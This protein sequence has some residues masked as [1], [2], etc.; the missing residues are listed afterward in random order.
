[1]T[2]RLSLNVGFVLGMAGIAAASTWSAAQQARDTAA[3]AAEAASTAVVAGTV[4]SDEAQ[5]RPVR[6]AKLT[7]AG[8]GLRGS[9]DTVTDD[10]GRFAFSGLAAGDYTLMAA[11]AGWITTYFG[12][13]HPGVRP[14][15]SAPLTMAA[16]ERNTTLVL[17]LLHGSAVSGTILDHAGRPADVIVRLLQF[18]IT[19]GQRTLVGASGAHTTDST[20]DRG[21]YRLYGIAP[22]EYVV[23]TVIQSFGE[24]DLHQVTAAVLQSA[25]RATSAGAVAPSGSA[26]SDQG[27]TVAYANVYYPGT[28][29]MAEAAIVKIGPDEDKSGVDFSLQLVPTAQISGAIVSPD[30]QPARVQVQL[31]PRRQA[32][33]ADSPVLG[34]FAFLA[35][36]VALTRVQADGTFKISAVPP[37]QYTV[38]AR[39]A[40]RSVAPAATADA[41]GPLGRAGGAAALTL[42]ASQDVTVS[43]RDISGV[44][45]NLQP[46][47]TVSGHVTSDI[48]GPAPFDFT[49]VAVVLNS[50][51][52]GSAVAPAAVDADGSFRLS[53]VVPGRYRLN[54]SA[55][56]NGRRAG[57]G[58]N[59]PSDW[60]VASAFVG[61]HDAIDLPFQVPPGE[62]ITDAAIKLTSALS[63]I[64]GRL[65]DAAGQPAHDY[66]I[67]VFSADRGYWTTTGRR[68]PPPTAT[69]RDGTFRISN[70]PA[71]E[72]LVLV[73]T[74]I[75][76]DTLHDPAQLETLSAQAVRVRLADGEKK[77]QDFKIGG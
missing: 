2:R 29:D 44:T 77:V 46:G 22:G 54:V 42:W 53:G 6:R 57:G 49:R 37:G 55:S 51:D 21:M 4:V 27:P 31:V 13:H 74:D 20:D 60:K 48:A 35:G 70:L 19:N 28:V 65:T 38:L 12:S 67:A 1:M 66:V 47:M 73:A 61:G 39:A 40:D 18:R 41:V 32:V 26:P 58:P 68:M 50:V 30:G 16:G 34:S 56:A 69:A 8:G 15:G 25:A 64:A 5:P 45:L 62:N 43:G 33:Q 10:Q 23:S 9:R 72:Y 3:P 24:E 63:E 17:R 76:S 36:F 71:G 59:G 52:Q 75:D 14:Y 7:I 11:K